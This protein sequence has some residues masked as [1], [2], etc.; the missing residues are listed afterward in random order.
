MCTSVSFD[1]DGALLM[2]WIVGPA[3]VVLM[4]LGLVYFIAFSFCCEFP[5]RDSQTLA[6]PLRTLCAPLRRA[7]FRLIL[8]RGDVAAHL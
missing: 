3:L 6:A 5:F 2:P 7:R 4:I 1:R 8:G